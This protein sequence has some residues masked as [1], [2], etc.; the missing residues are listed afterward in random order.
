MNPNLNYGQIQRGAGDQVGSR[1]GIL[2]V[3]FYVPKEGNALKPCLYSDLKAM[4]KVSTAV[5]ILRKGKSTQ[6]TSDLDNQLILW[7]NEYI[8]WHETAAIAVEES[9]ASK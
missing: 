6:W 5:L 8:N 4:A 1:T 2:W 3:L 9:V 7:V